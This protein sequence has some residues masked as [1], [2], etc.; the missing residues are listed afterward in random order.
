[1]SASRGRIA[2]CSQR[3]RISSLTFR[4]RPCEICNDEK[5]LILSGLFLD[6]F[7][8]QVVNAAVGGMRATVYVLRTRVQSCDHDLQSMVELMKILITD[9]GDDTSTAA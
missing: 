5:A 9:Y 7:V 2:P 8:D 3:I 6:P 1:M 4:H